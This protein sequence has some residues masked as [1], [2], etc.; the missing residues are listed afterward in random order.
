MTDNNRQQPPVTDSK[1]E[2]VDC[3]AMYQVKQYGTCPFC[4]KTICQHCAVLHVEECEIRSF[5]DSPSIGD[6]DES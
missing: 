2:C 5:E 3:E 6:E 4:H 1:R